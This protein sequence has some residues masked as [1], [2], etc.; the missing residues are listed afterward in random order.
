MIKISKFLKNNRNFYVITFFLIKREV[1]KCYV[2]IAIGESSMCNVSHLLDRVVEFKILDNNM[3]TKSIVLNI[4]KSEIK[5]IYTK[6]KHQQ[7]LIVCSNKNLELDVNSFD[8]WELRCMF[9]DIIFD[10][11]FPIIQNGDQEIFS[12]VVRYID[13][14]YEKMNT[15][16]P[17]YLERKN[18]NKYE[19][20]IL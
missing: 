19:G 9:K 15:L 16:R 8:Y 13:A 1:D 6:N 10:T 4:I 17:L 2:H 5:K 7:T 20:L 14:M 3:S 18:K 11:Y 12:H